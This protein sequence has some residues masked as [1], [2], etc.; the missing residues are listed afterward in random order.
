MT[1]LTFEAFVRTKDQHAFYNEKA[2]GHLRQRQALWGDIER[3]RA[4]GKT[5]GCSNCNLWELYR[6]I[7]W[8]QPTE[9]LECG[10]GLSTV[11]IAHALLKN[12]AEKHEGRLTSMEDQPEF[13][14]EHQRLCPPALKPFVDYTLSPKRDVAVYCF[15]GVAYA[16]IPNRPYEFVFVDGPYHG[17]SAT[18]QMTCDLDFLGVVARSTTPVWGL[19]DGRITTVY[20]LQS[21]LP[22]SQVRFDPKRGITSLGP[23]TREDMP[24]LES[25]VLFYGAMSRRNDPTRYVPVSLR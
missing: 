8:L 4:D 5:T 21:L 18:G 1:G 11:A 2:A 20:A 10:S 15:S 16:D 6:T 3:Y 14:E 24:S 19:I 9:V 23:L 13:F 7:W 17:S 25:T 12:Q 22:K